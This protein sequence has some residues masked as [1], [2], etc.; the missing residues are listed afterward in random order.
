MSSLK[1]NFL[2]SRL[3]FQRS[4]LISL[5]AEQRVGSEDAFRPSAHVM[6]IT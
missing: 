5:I 6:N 1:E 3:S 4:V 2:L